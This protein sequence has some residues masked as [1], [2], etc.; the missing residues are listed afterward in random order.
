VVQ[1]RGSIV[2]IAILPGDSGPVVAPGGT[3]LAVVCQVRESHLALAVHRVLDVADAPL[4][5]SQQPLR[6]GFTRTA[7]VEGK[8]TEFVALE[9]APLWKQEPRS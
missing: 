4:D 6:P 9:E 2:P 1:Y 5:D 8:V 3:F 7:V